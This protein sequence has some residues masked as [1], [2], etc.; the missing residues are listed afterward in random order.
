MAFPA[1]VL[2][3]KAQMKIDSVWTDVTS[4]VRNEGDIAITGGFA[5]EQTTLSPCNIAFTLNNRDGLFTDD[6]PSSPY[7]G[8]LPVN[9]PFRVGVDEPTTFLRQFNKINTD[10]LTGSMS[11]VG[12]IQTDDKASLDVTGDLDLRIEIDPDVWSLGSVGHQ[13][14]GKYTITGAQR[15]WAWSIQA[16]GR[17]RLYWSAD[18]NNA[19]T[20]GTY[21]DS[22]VRVPATGRIAL[23]VTIDVNNGAAGRTITFYTSDSITGT[24]TQLGAQVI[25]SGTTSIFSGTSKVSVGAFVDSATAAFPLVTDAAAGYTLPFSGRIYRFMMYNGIAGTLVADMNAVGQ[26]DSVNAAHGWT[27]TCA[28]PNTWVMQRET[29]VKATD[30]RAYGE[31][32]EMPQEWDITGTDVYIPT[33]ANGIMRRITQGA[34]PLK[35][36]I[37]R[38]LSQFIGAGALG[39]WPLEGGSQTVAAGNAVP[40]GNPA[41]VNNVLFQTD[42]TLPGS[43]GVMT[44]NDS[45]SYIRATSTARTATSTSFLIFYIKIPTTPGANIDLVNFYTLGTIRRVQFSATSTSYTVSAYDNLDAGLGALSGAFGATAAPGQWIAFEIKLVTNGAGVDVNLA[46]YALGT[47]VN[48]YGITLN[49]ATATNGAPTGFYTT[50]GAGTAQCSFAHIMMGNLVGWDYTTEAFARSSVGYDEEKAAVRY[51]R[52]CQEEGIEA[53]CIG[54]PDDTEPMGPQPIANLVDILDECVALDGGLQFEAKDQGALVIRTRSSLYGQDPITLDYSL[55][56]LSGIFRPTADDRL[57]RNDVTVQ[58]P[59]GSFANVRRESGP[60]SVLPPPNGVGPYDTS[61]TRN[62]SSDLRLPSLAGWEVGKGTW[63]DRRVPNIEVWLQRNVFVAS[64]TL[65][66]QMRW[67]HPG[68]RLRILNP[69]IWTGGATQDTMI[70]GYRETLKNR[71]HE[72]AF[73]SVPYGPYDAARYDDPNAA[74]VIRYDVRTSTLQSA[75]TSS[76]TWAQVASS[77]RRGFWSWKSIPYDIKISGQTNTVKGATR[78]DSISQQDTSFEDNTTTGWSAGGGSLAIST[79]QKPYGTASLLLTVSGSPVTAT[80]V[81]DIGA[82]AAVGGRYQVQAWVRVS[83]TRTV[84]WYIDWLDSG[85]NYLSTSANEVTVTANTWT[86]IGATASYIAPAS[87]AFAQQGLYMGLSPAN[88]TLLYIKNLDLMRIDVRNRRQL[89]LISRG[90]PTK[91]LLAGAEVHIAKQR[92]WAL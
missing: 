78:P 84:G 23:R 76:E 19:F 40:R 25:Q 48:F 4:R 67:L 39:Y 18:G 92:G 36:P 47:R 88:G 29:E 45:T 1:S 62:A 77:S 37:F 91:A 81:D 65:T 74:N 14:A 21:A 51:L 13:L 28:S 26:P 63:P 52:V 55:N 56:H 50:S 70:R 59:T 54:W 43:A 7:Y 90:S 83:V 87:T 9:T 72:I 33:S 35:S 82:I 8:L 61:L 57:L 44:L 2:P 49:I 89:L 30:Y 10:P 22:T 11:S 42:E 66:R 71:G 46:W 60:K 86:E 5:P 58:R 16:N 3:I 80:V 15:S 24:W 69:P 53:R 73:S 27:D 34:S 68:A 75:M 85:F 6:N 32:S 38:N 31:I 79:A 12:W 64:A 17:M 20:N 41:A